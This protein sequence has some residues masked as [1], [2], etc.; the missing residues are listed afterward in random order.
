MP[1][2]SRASSRSRSRSRRK[3]CNSSTRAPFLATSKVGG[4]VAP[5]VLHGRRRERGDNRDRSG[6]GLHHWRR[7]DQRPE[8][9]CQEQL[10][11]T[12]KFLKNGSLQEITASWRGAEAPLPS[13]PATR[14]SKAPP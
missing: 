6:H 2:T 4:T 3:R 14:R 10:G 12:V 13:P 8:H 7:L 11:F 1:T 5:R 9:E